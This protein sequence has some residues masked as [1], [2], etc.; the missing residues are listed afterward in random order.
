[1]TN[2]DI[3]DFQYPISE[4]TLAR[5]ADEL[6]RDLKLQELEERVRKLEATREENNE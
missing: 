5:L 2:T 6:R 4:S 3:P 1:M